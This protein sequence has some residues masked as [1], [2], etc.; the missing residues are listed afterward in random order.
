[1][2]FVNS[3]FWLPWKLHLSIKEKQTVVWDQQ[4]CAFFRLFC[5][6]PQHCYTTLTWGR[7]S[8]LWLPISEYLVS[9]QCLLF[10][11]SSGQV[12]QI[13]VHAV[14]SLLF[15]GFQNG[16]TQLWKYTVLYQMVCAYILIIVKELLISQWATRNGFVACWYQG[17]RGDASYIGDMN[18]SILQVKGTEPKKFENHCSICQH[19]L[20]S[21]LI[22]T[23]FCKTASIKNTGSHSKQ[24]SFFTLSAS[25]WIFFLLEKRYSQQEL[26]SL[27]S[28][29]Q[30]AGFLNCRIFFFNL[31][32]AYRSFLFLTV[33][34]SFLPYPSCFLLPVL[35]IYFSY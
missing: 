24:K 2:L 10:L 30:H 14:P 33:Q 15:N 17:P 21:A 11:W 7:Y 22:Q 31:S 16:Y 27:K 26:P 9:Q 20:F 8:V 13:L 3:R 5:C 18:C 35:Y 1:M 32:W 23:D 19:P 12:S 6:K 28:N 29:C 34:P 25:I 4:D